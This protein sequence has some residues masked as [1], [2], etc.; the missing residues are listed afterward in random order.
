MDRLR[1]AVLIIRS[2]RRLAESDIFRAEPHCHFVKFSGLLPADS[3]VRG[4]VR[5]AESL[6]PRETT[7]SACVWERCCSR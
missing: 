1:T 7:T 4:A 2:A 3:M 5:H 6:P